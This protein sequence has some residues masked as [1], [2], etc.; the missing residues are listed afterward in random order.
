[1]SYSPNLSM[2][3]HITITTD[4]VDKDFLPSVVSPHFGTIYHVFQV[5]LDT[6]SSRQIQKGGVEVSHSA[7]TPDFCTRCHPLQA[8]LMQSPPCLHQILKGR[9]EGFL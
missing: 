6:V 4:V 8:A 7:V 2:N 1:M 5:T 3:D 9:V